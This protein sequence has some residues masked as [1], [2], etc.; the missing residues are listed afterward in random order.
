MTLAKQ[1]ELSSTTTWAQQTLAPAAH[2]HLA[3]TA[4]PAPRWIRSPASAHNAQS[5]MCRVSAPLVGL[6]VLSSMVSKADLPLIVKVEHATHPRRSP[7]PIRAFACAR[8]GISP[9]LDRCPARSSVKPSLAQLALTEIPNLV[10]S[11]PGLSDPD[12][13]LTRPIAGCT[14]CPA[15]SVSIEAGD[16]CVLCPAG[17]FSSV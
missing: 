5:D 9:S 17:S 4:R 11:C 3:S 15:G 14:A 10:R 7:T 13:R 16:E 1:L 6:F 12:I 8:M 2:P